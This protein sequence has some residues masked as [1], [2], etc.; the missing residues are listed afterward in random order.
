M[1]CLP[2][3]TKC[4]LCGIEE[5]ERE[6]G[7]GFMGWCQIMGVFDDDK[8]HMKEKVNPMVCP[9]CK[10]KLVQYMNILEK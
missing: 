1:F 4:G 8:M 3:T 9:K 6:Y 10:F 2:R 7:E 5:T